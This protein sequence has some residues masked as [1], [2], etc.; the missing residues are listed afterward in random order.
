MASTVEGDLVVRGS[1][2]A[3]KFAVPSESV[4]NTQF[5]PADPLAATKQDHQYVKGF[6]QPH[7]TA[8]VAERRA[9]HVAHAPGQVVDITVG[10]VVANIGGA[11]ITIDLRNNDTTILSTPLVLDNTNAAFTSIPGTLSATS[12]SA[13]DVLEIVVTVSVGGGTLGQGLFAKL[14]VRESAD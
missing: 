14:T 3:N 10:V 1:L 4:G 11:T 13:G 8:A 6:A 2:R 5:N 9:I 12:L 7:G